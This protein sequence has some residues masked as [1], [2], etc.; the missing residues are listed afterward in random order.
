MAFGFTTPITRQAFV[1]QRLFSMNAS[2]TWLIVCVYG[3]HAPP[4]GLPA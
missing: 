2:T 3:K 1:S 4:H